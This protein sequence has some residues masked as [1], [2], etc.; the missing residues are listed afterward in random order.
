MSD[1]YKHWFSGVLLKIEKD[2]NRV[3]RLSD[4][5]KID[6]YWKDEDIKRIVNDFKPNYLNVE[7]V[8]IPHSGIIKQDILKKDI[9]VY[10]FLN[11]WESVYFPFLKSISG[12]NK[13]I[14]TI[15]KN[16]NIPKNIDTRITPMI[17]KIRFQLERLERYL[18]EMKKFAG[19]INKTDVS[20]SNDSNHRNKKKGQ[21]KKIDKTPLDFF[22]H[23]Q[24]KID[25]L[26]EVL[27]K[28]DLI[29]DNNKWLEKPRHFNSM[30]MVLV[31]KGYVKK[32]VPR[33]E[34]LRILSKI[35]KNNI[36]KKAINDNCPSDSNTY[37]L[38]NKKL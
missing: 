1:F 26:L 22:K 38:L 19:L 10:E 34:A 24:E 7:R 12:N 6:G 4:E 37:E 29:D 9:E 16:K 27:K 28:E 2:L 5:I 32:H 13:T 30:Y 18:V 23:N 25:K 33:A 3:S 17:E 8:D 15:I 36:N 31:E 21:L 35:I 14:E 11:Y 20:D